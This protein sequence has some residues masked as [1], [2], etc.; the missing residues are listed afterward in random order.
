MHLGGMASVG[1]SNSNNFRHILLNNGVHDSV[2]GQPTLGTSISF[3]KIAASCGY[4]KIKGPLSDADTI[5]A[6]LNFLFDFDG[7]SFIEIEV[8][9]GARKDLGRPKELPA[10]NK[11]LFQKLLREEK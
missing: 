9:P 3:T 10:Q 1:S 4:K 6:D 8:K 5:K 11:E 7:P 2:G